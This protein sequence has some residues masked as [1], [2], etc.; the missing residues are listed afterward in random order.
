MSPGL[1]ED[2]FEGIVLSWF[3]EL[4]YTHMY[5]PHIGPGEAHEERF[6][7]LFPCVFFEDDKMTDKIQKAVFLED[8]PDQDFNSLY[9]RGSPIFS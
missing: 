4:G 8:A 6:D 5:G 3:G 9:M 7:R 1:T 2:D